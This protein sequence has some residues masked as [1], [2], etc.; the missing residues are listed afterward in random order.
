MID[1]PHLERLIRD[2]SSKGL[3][4]EDICVTLKIRGDWVRRVVL[5]VKDQ[6]AGD[7]KRPETSVQVAYR[8]GR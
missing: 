4:W 8:R 1:T 7:G 2:L 6:R 3:G 5:D